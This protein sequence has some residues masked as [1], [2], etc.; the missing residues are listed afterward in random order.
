MRML[1]ELADCDGG[2]FLGE[3]TGLFALLSSILG[4][5]L[6]CYGNLANAGSGLLSSTVLTSTA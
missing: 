1:G 5:Y 2:L 3:T 6:V 4:G